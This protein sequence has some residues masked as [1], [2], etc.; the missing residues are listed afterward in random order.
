MTSHCTVNFVITD[1]V[2][3]YPRLVRTSF[4]ARTPQASK[5]PLYNG[6]Q[7]GPTGQG[8][9]VRRSAWTH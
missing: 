3:T 5:G 1:S 2:K 9:V 4:L 6:L 8:S 7:H